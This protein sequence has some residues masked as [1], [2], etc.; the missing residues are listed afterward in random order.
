MADVP[1]V[2]ICLY[3]SLDAENHEMMYIDV[4]QAFKLRDQANPKRLSHIFVCN[5][6]VL[7]S[8]EG[9]EEQP[10]KT[11]RHRA[12]PRGAGLGTNPW[13]PVALWYGTPAS[14]TSSSHPESVEVQKVNKLAEKHW[15]LY[16]SGDPER[17]SS[18]HL[19][20]YPIGV[21]SDGVSRELPRLEFFL[22]T[23]LGTT[24]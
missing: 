20:S 13:L 23:K 16:A 19:L 1:G 7:R 4:V 8:G 2:G 5:R 15:D 9:T 14:T 21:A 18:G 24:S 12:Q 22:D 10:Q 3:Y 17:G 11:S 6:E